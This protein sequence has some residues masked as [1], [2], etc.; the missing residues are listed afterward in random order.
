MEKKIDIL[1][2]MAVLSDLI[3]RLPIDSKSST[4][5]FELSNVEFEKI[6]DIIQKKYNR[7]S[8]LP[9]NTFTI[10]IGRLDIIFNTNNV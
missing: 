6:F 4:I 5:I 7:K 10:S 1:N 3:E 8:E 9:K 2:Q